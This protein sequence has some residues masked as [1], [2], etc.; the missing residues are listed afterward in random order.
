MIFTQIDN[1][2]PAD[3]KCNIREVVS[4]AISN[5]ISVVVDLITIS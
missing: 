3:I 1:I 2:L 4:E 5:D